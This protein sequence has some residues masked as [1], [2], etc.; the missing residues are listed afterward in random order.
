MKQLNRFDQYSLKYFIYTSP[1]FII[2]MIWASYEFSGVADKTTMNGGIW[3]YFAGFFIA[4]VLILL[5]TVT[6]MLFSKNFRD[7]TMARLAGIKERDEREVV[8]AGNAAKYS[9]LSTF[10]LLLFMLVFSITTFNLEK[11]VVPTTGKNGT[12]SIGFGMKALDETAYVHEVKEGVERY[13]YKSLPLSKPFMILILMFWQ[14]GSYHL[15][16][17]RELRE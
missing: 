4:W 11:K 12:F 3:N 10:A 5:Y 16:A 6:K 15:M 2:F 7:I 14:I 1:V 17:R 13:N 8:V 9:F